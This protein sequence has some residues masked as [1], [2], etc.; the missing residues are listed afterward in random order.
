M[1][2]RQVPS[3]RRVRQAC[4]QIQRP[5]SPAQRQHRRI[6]A[7]ERQRDLIRLLAGATDAQPEAA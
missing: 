6:V 2:G 4:Q 1:S 5:W 3:S 7:Q